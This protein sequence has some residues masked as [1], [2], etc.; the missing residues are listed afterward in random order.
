[1]YK[2]AEPRMSNAESLQVRLF[3]YR[4]DGSVYIYIYIASDDEKII[5]W[6]QGVLYSKQEEWCK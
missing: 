4:V 5:K 3:Q 6:Y 1:M 2:M